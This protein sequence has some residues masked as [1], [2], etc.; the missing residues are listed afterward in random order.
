MVVLEDLNRSEQRRHICAFCYADNAILNKSTCMV[1][2]DLVLS[3][4]RECNINVE[5][6][7]LDDVPNRFCSEVFCLWIF[8]QI[9]ANPSPSCIL[10]VHDKGK[11][12]GI[13]TF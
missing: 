8:M 5:T 2:A 11:L 3:G 6:F 9:L 13:D 10:E 1:F 12:F 7:F 4:A